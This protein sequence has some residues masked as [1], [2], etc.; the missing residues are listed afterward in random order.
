L[1]DLQFLALAGNQLKRLENIEHLERL[2][3][4][5]VSENEIEIDAAKG[6]EEET[7]DEGDQNAPH[8][9]DQNAR[10]QVQLNN[11]AG[12]ITS[13]FPP[14]LRICN[15]EGNPCDTEHLHKQMIQSL[16]RLMNLNDE[17]VTVEKRLQSGLSIGEG[18][19]EEFEAV[20]DA[21][22]STLPTESSG[23]PKSHS[24][25]QTQ[26]PDVPPSS[27]P[28]TSQPSAISQKYLQRMESILTSASTTSHDRPLKIHL[29]E[30]SSEHSLLTEEYA[31]QLNSVTTQVHSSIQGAFQSRIKASQERLEK[32]RKKD[33][34]TKL[35]KPILSR[36]S[37]LSSLGSMRRRG[38]DLP[39]LERKDVGD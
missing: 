39:P 8:N 21:L 26:D 27:S 33:L 1:Y 29:H 37:S 34:K 2:Y 5:D 19:A 13:A 28:P 15:I 36:N 14:N 18:Y 35:S 32:M 11:S 3:F 6:P 10:E 25:T 17:P 23:H 20:N 4:L 9:Q 31:Q 24:A 22:G 38:K 7:N 16:P 12:M 30:L